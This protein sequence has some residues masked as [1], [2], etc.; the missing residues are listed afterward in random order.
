MDVSKSPPPEQQ[1]PQKPQEPQ[2]QQKPQGPQKP[3]APPSL[4]SIIVLFLTLCVGLALSMSVG[5]LKQIFSNFASYRCNPV[6]M[7]FAGLFGYNASENFQFCLSNILQGR[8]AEVFSPLFSLLGTFGKTLEMVVN[9][10]L[11]LRKL[12]SNFLLTVNGFIS[13]VQSRI[14]MLMTT[15]RMSFLKMKEL[16]GKVYGTMFA[17]V[18]LGTS[19]LTAAGNLADN[20]LVKFM[21]EFCFA[22]ETVV[23]LED[24]TQKTMESLEM[25]DRLAPLP[26]G[27]SPCSGFTPVVTSL[28]RFDGRKTPMVRIGDVVVSASHFVEWDGKMVEATEHPHAIPLP[29]L[30]AL[31]C[32][33]VTGHRFLVGT[34]GLV[35]ADYD[36]DE[37]AEVIAATQA[38]AIAAL[39]GTKDNKNREAVVSDYSLGLDGD[40]EVHMANGEWKRLSSI[41]VGDEVAYSGAVKGVVREQCAATVQTSVGPMA[42]AQLVF[43]EEAWRRGHT[44]REATGAAAAQVLHQ[45]ITERCGVLEV[46]KGAATLFVRE[47]REVALP[48]ME[49]AY[50]ARLKC[51]T[52]VQC[53]TPPPTAPASL[54][55]PFN[56][57]TGPQGIPSNSKEAV[58]STTTP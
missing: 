28:F 13:N 34:Q 49:E 23:V 55:I 40:V 33:N 47:Y 9:A 46:R 39:N 41:V 5:Y 31:C 45:L 43:S 14:K 58:P 17:V 4:F 7:P 24:G 1:E 8:L 22:P 32:I 12:F 42:A 51:G 18:G 29:S 54:A 19:G 50:A 53:A 26:S 48:E 11:G 37:S 44:V 16:M 52:S 2:E 35:A 6:M 36:E 20:N 15:V 38:V 3:E 56:R 27:V 10:A 57:P 21:L 25:G 30:P